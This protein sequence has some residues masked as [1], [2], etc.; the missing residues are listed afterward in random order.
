[1]KL[2]FSLLFFIAVFAV[3][4]QEKLSDRI[5][6]GGG[7]GLNA[8]SNV[9]NISVA[10]Q[11]GYKI[12]PRFSAGVGII[13]QYVKFRQI[14]S[15]ISNY[16][17]NVFSRYNLTRQFFAYTEFESLR[18]EYFT[19]IAPEQTAR[20]TYN[21]LL[22]GGGYSESL[23]RR[24]AISFSVLYNVLYDQSDPIQPYNSPWVIRAG[25]GVGI[26]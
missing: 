18:F 1:M 3:S 19:S 4:A 6:F 8:G 20:D 14:N 24:A 23:S 15:S 16:G 26:F 22:I 2:G 9:T 12:T 17:W 10:P 13:Y 11:V 25:V 5:Y 21:S 7:F